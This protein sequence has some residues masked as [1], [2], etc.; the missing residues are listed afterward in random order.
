MPLGWSA[1]PD[2]PTVNDANGIGLTLVL[3]FKETPFLLWSTVALLARPELALQ[4]RGWLASGRTLGYSDGAL[5]WRVLWPLLLPR[6]AWPLL[7]VLAYGLTVVDLA[8]IV[9]PALAADAGR[10]RLAIA[11]G[12]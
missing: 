7:A 10:D 9:G 12:R 11:A 4:L 5:W 2:W 6:L 8:L 3:I 1:P